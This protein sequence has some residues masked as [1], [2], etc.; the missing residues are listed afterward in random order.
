MNI[1][2]AFINSFQKKKMIK[3]RKQK[4]KKDT[5]MIQCCFSLSYGFESSFSSIFAL[6]VLV[7][8]R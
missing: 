1:I 4:E 5:E 2:E 6:L 8:S 7:R 3:K